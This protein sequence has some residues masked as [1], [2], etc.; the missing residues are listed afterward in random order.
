MNW[1]T[2]LLAA[3][4]GYLLGSV[5]FARIVMRLVAPDVAL[6]GIELEAPAT[7]EK[8][9]VSAISGTAVSVKLG[10]KWGGIT[11]I[12]DILKVA[13]PT[14]AFRLI[15]RD[16]PYYLITA[17][18]G[19]VGHSWP[20]YHR[21]KGG[22]GISPMTGGFLV[23]APLGTI[24]SSVVGLFAGLALRQVVLSYMLWP[25]FMIPWVWWRTRDAAHVGYAVAVNVLFLLALVPDLPGIVSRARRGANGDYMAAMEMTPQGR[26]IKRIGVRLG[27]IKED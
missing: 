11:G 4:V 23:I 24:V 1:M 16:A 9:H 12:L 2:A 13:V 7:G 6:T 22:R 17:T 27:L 8:I 3:A 14:L 5:S 19:M 20:L 10:G 15:V 25:W 21:F 26:G 18:M